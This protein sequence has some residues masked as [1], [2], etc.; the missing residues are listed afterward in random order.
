MT[1][2]IS[3]YNTDLYRNAKQREILLCTYV[4]TSC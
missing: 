3:D 2:I 4:E 1:N